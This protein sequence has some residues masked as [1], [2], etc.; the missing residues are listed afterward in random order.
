LDGHTASLANDLTVAFTV[1][2]GGAIAWGE[3][4]PSGTLAINGDWRVT[5]E[6]RSHHLTLTTTEPLVY[7]A[8]CGGI[9]GGTLV[10]VGDGGEVSVTWTACRVHAAVFNGE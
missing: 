9:V 1:A 10:A 4:L 2:Q 7:D 8:A 3:P 5:T 6:E